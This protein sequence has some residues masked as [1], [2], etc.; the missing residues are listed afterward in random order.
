MSENN[1]DLNMVVHAMQ[2]GAKIQRFQDILLEYQNEFKGWDP[3]DEQEKALK[4]AKEVLIFA[5]MDEYGVLFDNIL[6]RG[7]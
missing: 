4:E 3:E 7:L 6:A 5:L 1:D 2:I